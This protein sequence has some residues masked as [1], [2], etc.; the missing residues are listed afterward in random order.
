MKKYIFSAIC[1]ATFGLGAAEFQHKISIKPVTNETG[2]QTYLAQ[3]QIEKIDDNAV[4][5]VVAKPEIVCV[6]GKLGK[7][8]TGSAEEPDHLLVTVL[9]FKDNEEMKAKTTINLK[10]ENKE[11]F[12][13]EQD[14]VVNNS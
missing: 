8:E 5:S 4:A 12:A 14:V 10:E 3:V 6:E 7:I 9:V 13:V 1:L 11:V 2:E